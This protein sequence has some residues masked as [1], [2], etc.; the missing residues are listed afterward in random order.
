M[1]LTDGY[2]ATVVRSIG[3]PSMWAEDCMQEMRIKLWAMKDGAKPSDV[4]WSAAIDFHRKLSHYHRSQNTARNMLTFSEVEARSQLK[5]VSALSYLVYPM[6][7]IDD[8]I[9]CRDALS[10]LNPRRLRLMAALARG[11]TMRSMAAREGVTE[12]RIAQL[13]QKT[14]SQLRAIA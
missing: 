7:P 4:A 11:E 3:V 8:V 9:D 12:G 2:L 1:Q 6:S 10:Q 13:V 5:G 14:R